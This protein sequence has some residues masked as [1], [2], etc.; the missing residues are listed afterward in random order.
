MDKLTGVGIGTTGNGI[1]P[2]YAERSMRMID[3]ILSNIRAI[4]LLTNPEECI[5]IVRERLKK[6]ISLDKNL[7]INT[8]VD[9]F[10]RSIDGI[11]KFILKD[12]YWMVNRLQNGA[13]V[14]LEGAQSYWLDEVYGN[15]PF[16]TSSRTVPAAACLGADIPPQYLRHVDMVGKFV[17][18]RVGTG[19]YVGE[20]GG[21][22]SEEYC[23]VD[24]G[25]KYTK[26]IEKSLYNLDELLFSNDPLDL[27]IALRMLTGNY[28]ARTGRPRR[29]GLPDL[30]LM[31]DACLMNSPR[32]VFLNQLDCLHYFSRMPFYKEGIPFI[33]GYKLDGQVVDHVPASTAEIWKVEP[34]TTYI[35]HITED[36]S[37]ITDFEKLPDSA[38][39]VIGFVQ[40]QIGAS[41]IG[42]GTGPRRKDMVMLKT[43]IV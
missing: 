27:G 14:S 2:A 17:P 35:P 38:K 30:V 5:L 13:K 26:D 32:G 25:Y 22:R 4:D 15:V 21:K 33:T 11:S 9:D 12:Q 39:N 1:G 42:V 29:T 34:I 36:I 28:G 10:R 37:G 24:G 40:E 18:S 16:V 23:A 6:Y 31:R 43:N 8:T 3:G 20:L 7:N 19:P 41:L